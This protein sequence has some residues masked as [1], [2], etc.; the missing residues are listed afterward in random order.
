MQYY[1]F[2]NFAIAILVFCMCIVYVY[3]FSLFQA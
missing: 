3:F 1:K 2:N